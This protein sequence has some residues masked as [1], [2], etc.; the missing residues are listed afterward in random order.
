M[1]RWQTNHVWRQVRVCHSLLG[2]VLLSW[3]MT[4]SPVLCK[5]LRVP[6]SLSQAVLLVETLEGKWKWVSTTNQP[7]LTTGESLSFSS[8]AWFIVEVYDSLRSSLWNSSSTLLIVTSCSL[9][10]EILGG[11]YRRVA[12]TLRQTSHVWRQ[13]RV[14]HSLLGLVLLTWSMTS[15]PV[16]CEILRVPSSLSQEVL[17]VETLGGKRRRV[18]KTL[19]QTNYVWRR[20]RVCYSLLGLV[21]MNLFVVSSDPLI[22]HY[23]PLLWAKTRDIQ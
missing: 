16:P 22:R 7:C 23:M 6:S 13:V 1:T 5:I 18:T 17:L 2:L 9:F 15:S 21:F 12:K 11:T 8:W 10:L 20:V 19:R 14:C 4:R 3:S